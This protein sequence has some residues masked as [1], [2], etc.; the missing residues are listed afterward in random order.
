MAVNWQIETD[1][2]WDGTFWILANFILNDIVY[3]VSL[4]YRRLS[5]AALSEQW[6]MPR[7]RQRLPLWLCARIQWDQLWKQCVLAILV[8]LSNAIKIISLKLVLLSQFSFDTPKCN[9]HLKHLLKISKTVMV[10]PVRTM[11]HVSISSTIT[12]VTVLQASMEPTAKTVCNITCSF[13]IFL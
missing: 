8:W 9:I 13:L 7:P 11:E 5:G 4:R 10:N 1:I 3:L 12:D 6:N 2:L